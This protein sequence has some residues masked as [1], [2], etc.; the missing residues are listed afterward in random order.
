MTRWAQAVGWSGFV[1][2]VALFSC[3][4]VSPPTSSTTNPG[5]VSPPM[6][7]PSWTPS[8]TS[9]PTETRLLRPSP[10]VSPTSTPF[11]TNTP[12]ATVPWLPGMQ[13]PREAVVPVDWPPLSTD[14]YFVQEG[15]LWHW[16][17]GG[18][19]PQA[20]PV[21]AGDPVRW[22]RLLPGNAGAVYWSET[23]HLH[24]VELRSSRGSRSWSLTWISDEPAREYRL[25]R[26]GRML[27]YLTESGYLRGAR[28]LSSDLMDGGKHE[29][30]LSSDPVRS[31]LLASDERAI[32][33]LTQA[34]R[35]FATQPLFPDPVSYALTAEGQ[36]VHTF[37]VSPDGR[38]VVYQVAEGFYLLDRV[39]GSLHF[40]AGAISQHQFTPDSQYLVYLASE[41][42]YALDVQTPGEPFVVGSCVNGTDG[43]CNV[44]CKGF[45]VSPDGKNVIYADAHGLW[46]APLS[47]GEPQLSMANGGDWQPCGPIV[48]LGSWSPD[49]RLLL[50]ERAYW[51][52]DDLA[53]LH[54]D[55][56]RAWVLPGSFCYVEC[57]RE[58]RWHSQGLWVTHSA[59]SGGGVY[60]AQVTDDGELE[61]VDW[62][63]PD[64]ETTG[65]CPVSLHSLPD[66]RIA[67]I[68]PGYCEGAGFDSGVAPAIF[69]IDAEGELERVAELPKF[70]R[71][72]SSD[73][74]LLWS[75][76]GDAFLY[77]VWTFDSAGRRMTP[78]PILLG[79]TD[80]SVLWDVRELLVGAT[81]FQWG[82][83]R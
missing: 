7:I 24:W 59:Y 33:Y 58:Q 34:G 17:A 26:D 44:R 81:E 8:V 46:V 53:L 10:T 12:A 27:L 62:F 77:E 39:S 13:L 71:R 54:V 25:T 69:V 60:R 16:P 76:G 30:A 3:W 37:A 35:L 43:E 31:Y 47:G 64:A 41:V 32:V 1:L 4:M 79:L 83:T 48:G 56:G 45:T 51:E 72:Y 78:V 70:E 5:T 9:S 15:R 18:G 68:H 38:Y 80:G 49:G 6:A 52:G 65:I 11:P 28:L 29:K 23:R 2:S 74:V 55:T 21:V 40:L 61:I 57:H 42:I 19:V 82:T 75:P 20:L 22:Y 66:G 63:P 50:L 36:E 67:F 14:L 73:D